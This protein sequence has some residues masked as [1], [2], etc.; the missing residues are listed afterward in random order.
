MLII[1]EKNDFKT[2]DQIEMHSVQTL[3]RRTLFVSSKLP[4]KEN[5]YGKTIASKLYGV[6]D[7][8]VVPVR[9]DVYDTNG[10]RKA[11]DEL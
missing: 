9:L 2:P 3:L 11:R 10:F 6:E 5:S 1:F 8:F 4:H 7:C